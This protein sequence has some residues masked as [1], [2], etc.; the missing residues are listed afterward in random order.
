MTL[1]RAEADL[2]MV[3][4]AIVLNTS[5][6]PGIAAG[7]SALEVAIERAQCLFRSKSVMTPAVTAN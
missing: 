4:Q 1:R 7:P 5:D 6:A 2:D 3:Y